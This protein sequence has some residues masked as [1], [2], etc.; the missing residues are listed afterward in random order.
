MS[1]D[2]QS[3]K[4][5]YVKACSYYEAKEYEMALSEINKVLSFDKNNISTRNLKACILIDSWNGDSKPRQNILEAID[6]LKVISEKDPKNKKIYSINLGNAYSQ[7]AKYDLK[8]EGK[9]NPSIIK[10][11]ET[12]KM[13]FQESLS[14]CE[15]QP[16][17]W[18]HKGNMLDYLGRHFEALYCYD[19]AI[20]LNSQHYNAWVNKG[21]CYWRL[22]N[23]VVNETDKM[24]LYRDAM[25]SLAIE[26]ELYPLSETDDLDKKLV[27]DFIQ[28]NRIVIDLEKTLEDQLP[29]KRT[30][31]KENFN[32]YFEQVGNFKDFYFNFCE[33]HGLFLN[34][35]FNC[36]NCRCSTS[37]SIEVN[38]ISDI[39]DEIKPYKFIKRWSTLI[40]DYK[41]ARFY[42]ALAQYRHPDF[43]FM[44]KPRYESDYSLNYYI[45]VEM[46]K[47]AFSI[48]FNIYDKVAFLL[49]DY[50]ELGLKDGNVSFWSGKS[51]FTINGMNLLKKNNW[52]VNLVALYS[53]KNEI[54]A[55]KEFTTIK[56]I[57]N[58]I[59]HRYFV[60]HDLIKVEKSSY[61]MDIQDFFH[62]TLY[63]LL[64]IKNI[65]FSL[66]FFILEKERLKKESAEKY[67]E[68]IPTVEWE[69]DWEKDDEITK[70][71]KETEKKLNEATDKFFESIF[72]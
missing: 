32:L 30:I 15:D 35:H 14:I 67:G 18:I 48:A 55:N 17:V 36:N 56:D 31:I 4:N 26:L 43:L 25:I 50:E 65:L 63:M 59:I 13:Y 10:N 27:N 9:L 21:I 19:R 54:E 37:D 49:N 62:S 64:Q 61:N 29:K 42:L 12:G 6:H 52:N 51:V 23:L 45:N 41:T 71:A 46:L 69:H 39:D 47:S 40:D 70:I 16:A 7:L 1:I 72:E 24:K 34:A 3:W 57:R 60:L 44:D 2:N 33:I 53:I 22:S 58:S 11:L 20:L 38:F 66:S 68:I 8:A 28:Q 5:D